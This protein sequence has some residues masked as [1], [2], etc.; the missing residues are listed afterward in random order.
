MS[1]RLQQTSIQLA[2]VQE[3]ERTT[4]EQYI[5]VSSKSATLE[6][7]LATIRE[8]KINLETLVTKVQMKQCEFLFL[9]YRFL[10]LL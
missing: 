6:A 4:A 2:A 5:Q 1:E 8:D 7:K 9:V 3:R 10:F